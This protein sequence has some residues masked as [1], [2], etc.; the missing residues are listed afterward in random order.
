[1]VVACVDSEHRALSLRAQ[2][3]VLT[4]ALAKQSPILYLEFQ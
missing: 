2:A 1:V 3:S 4:R